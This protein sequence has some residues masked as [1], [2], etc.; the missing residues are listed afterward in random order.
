[1]GTV[2]GKLAGWCGCCQRLL[3]APQHVANGAGLH[4]PQ[5]GDAA[6]QNGSQR[7]WWRRWFGG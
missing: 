6:A 5:P 4:V 1:M 7:S 3:N 2:G